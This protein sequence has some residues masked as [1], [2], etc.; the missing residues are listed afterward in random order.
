MCK[1]FDFIQSAEP[2]RLY[3]TY[4]ID[5]PKRETE[6]TQLTQLNIKLTKYKCRSSKYLCVENSR[7]KKM[8]VYQNRNCYD[9]LNL[10]QLIG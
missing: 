9:H 6:L 10:V 8:F 5:R 3:T 1:I 7:T 2:S 4:I